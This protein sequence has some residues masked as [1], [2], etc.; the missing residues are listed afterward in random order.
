MWVVLAESMAESTL[1][2]R[3]G[4]CAVYMGKAMAVYVGVAMAV[5]SV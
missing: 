5:L 2:M 3:V 1:C 4:L